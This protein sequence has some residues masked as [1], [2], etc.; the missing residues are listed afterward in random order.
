MSK[1][2]AL[3]PGLSGKTYTH[4]TFT[5]ATL[6]D[7]T[8]TSSGTFFQGREVNVLPDGRIVWA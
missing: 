7:L 5:P 3:F 1:A 2:G 4:Q 8:Y 6:A